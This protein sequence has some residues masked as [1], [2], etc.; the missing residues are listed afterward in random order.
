MKTEVINRGFIT[1]NAF[2]FKY[3]REQDNKYKAR[4]TH[5]TYMMNLEAI[6]MADFK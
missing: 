1:I 6:S 4:I 3:Y 5:N 2:L